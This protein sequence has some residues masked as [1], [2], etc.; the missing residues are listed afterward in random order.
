MKFDTRDKKPKVWNIAVLT[1]IEALFLAAALFSGAE[2][3]AAEISISFIVYFALVIALLIR[4]FFRQLQYNPY[5][6][7]TI[8][9]SGFAIFFCSALFTHARAAVMAYN[10]PV[11]RLTFV[12]I[13]FRAM[14]ESAYPAMNSVADDAIPDVKAGDPGANEI[15]VF[16]RAGVLSGYNDYSFGP[17]KS[18]TRAEGATIMNR[19]VDPSARQIFT[20]G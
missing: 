13:F 15:Y 3:R 10:T 6:Y 1:G 4:G 19:M 7:N 12:R 18:I 5:S 20:L 16:Y 9:Y 14:P 11:D 17:G 2:D 8:Y